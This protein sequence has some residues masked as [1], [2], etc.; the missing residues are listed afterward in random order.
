MLLYKSKNVGISEIPKNKIFEYLKDGDATIWEREPL[1]LLAKKG[2]LNLNFHEGFW[3][4]MDSL[5]DKME[6]NELWNSGKAEWK[7]WK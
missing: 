7:I 2:E 3:K 5:K 4:P 1:E 6:L